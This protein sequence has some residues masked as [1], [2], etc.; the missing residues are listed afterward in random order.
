MFEQRLGNDALRFS[1]KVPKF[2]CSRIE[3]WTQDSMIGVIC[4]VA[5]VFTEKDKE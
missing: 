1:V 4:L 5:A 2:C 3:F